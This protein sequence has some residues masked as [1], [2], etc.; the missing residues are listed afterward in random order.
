M[1]GLPCD[2]SGPHTNFLTAQPILKEVPAINQVT[3]GDFLL[4]EMHPTQNFEIAQLS[5]SS[6]SALLTSEN[7]GD[8]VPRQQHE[9]FHIDEIN[10]INHENCTSMPAQAE[11]PPAENGSENNESVPAPEEKSESLTDKKLKTKLLACANKTLKLPNIVDLLLDW[12]SFN[13]LMVDTGASHSLIPFNK[14]KNLDSSTEKNLQAFGGAP[15]S[16]CGSCILTIDLGFGDLPPHEF[17]VVEEDMDFLILGI[18]FLRANRLVL[19]TDNNTL[20]QTTTGLFAPTVHFTSPSNAAFRSA[21]FWSAYLSNSPLNISNEKTNLIAV[22]LNTTSDDYENWRALCLEK[23]ELF[24]DLELTP[25]YTNKPKHSVVFTLEK[26]EDFKVFHPRARRA[27]AANLKAARENF[28]D[29]MN[30]GGLKRGMSDCVSPITFVRKKDGSTRVCIDYT[31]LN[32]YTRTMQYPI[33][34][35]QSLPLHLTNRHKLF[36]VLDMKEAFY[37]I[38]MSEEASK[39]C[40]IIT[41]FGTFVPLR[42]QFGLKNAPAFFCKLVSDIVNGLESFVFTYLDDFLV[43]SESI[44]EHLDH[45]TQLF[46]R[47]D[48]FGMRI[49]RRKCLFAR[50]TV[51]FLGHEISAQGLRPLIDKVEAIRAMDPPTNLKELRA[52]LGSVNYYRKFLPMMA[53]KASPLTDLLKGPTRKKTARIVWGPDQQSAFETVKTTLAEAAT[54]AN[55]DPAA[56]LVLSTDASSHH[57]GGVLEQFIDPEESATNPLAFYSKA[58]PT[59]VRVRSVFNKELTAVYFTIKHFRHR[60]RGRNLIIRSD[61]KAVVS[62]IASP[63][64]GDHSPNECTMINY[65]KEYFP[66]MRH[67]PGEDNQMA[68]LLSRPA[69]HTPHDEEKMKNDPELICFIDGATRGDDF[70]SDSPDESQGESLDAATP[71]E[72]DPDELVAITPILIAKAQES[73]PQAMSEIRQRVSESKTLAMDERPLP[74][75]EKL[76]CYGVSNPEAD[77]FLPIIPSHLRA[78][79]FRLV[80]NTTHPGREKSLELLR[81]RYYWPEMTKD[82]SL[83]VKTCPACQRNKITR[84]MRQQLQNFPPNYERLSTFHI[85]LVGPLPVSEDF[86][87]VLTMRDR[88]TGYS[89][90]TPLR[91]KTALSVTEGIRQHLIGTMGIPRTLI[92]DNGGEF[93]GALF[94]DFCDDFGIQHRFTTPYHPQCNGLVE[95]LHRTLKQALRSLPDTDTWATHLPLIMLSINNTLSGTSS[96]TPHQQVFGKSGNIVGACIMDEGTVNSNEGVEHFYAFFQNM[97]LH[98]RTARPFTD[99]KPYVDQNLFTCDKVWIRVDKPS[100]SLSPRYNGP[101]KVL[102][103]HFKYFV[104][105]IDNRLSKVSIDRLK[106]VFELNNLD[107]IEDP[108]ADSEYDSDVTVSEDDM[109][110]PEFS[111][112][113]VNPGASNLGRHNPQRNRQPSSRLKDYYLGD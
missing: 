9:S 107:A 58:L 112:S 33:P 108:P 44:E 96:F 79:V 106:P 99:N 95:R 41:E 84:H 90:A 14:A 56:P 70:S 17:L 42:M 45:L 37:Q 21:L 12:R 74:S 47:L 73:D 111:P 36:S 103:R 63:T 60:I 30:R 20:E 15:I 57:I 67:I 43:F 46:K 109:G 28:A 86:K 16:V 82:I 19:R 104:V 100:P 11:K 34:L 69:G 54:L 10:V 68:D 83:W 61:H 39:L 92:S 66:L 87:Y 76:V 88:G 53:E 110:P 4:E 49:N 5:K 102:D 52:F 98:K 101:H 18:D 7:A 13:P 29:L 26:S 51:L 85:D 2:L 25:D 77:V 8:D 1:S 32:K 65:I 27:N 59:S 71:D 113:E 75:L 38:P 80:H 40:A 24:P 62:A 105:L 23:L 31:Q 6:T 81:G 93:V 64:D 50:E 78:V 91:D 89:L 55:E 48:Q 22:T 97:A 72:L 94:Q 3:T 35:I